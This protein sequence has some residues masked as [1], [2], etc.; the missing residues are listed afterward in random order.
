MTRPAVP[1]SGPQVASAPVTYLVDLS[2]RDQHLVTVTM[3]IP[4]D[5]A[6]TGGRLTVPTWTPG[7]Y[8]IRDY[9]HHLQR[10][11]ARDAAGRPV[12]LEP[13]GVS[14]WVLPPVDGEVVVDLEW[15]AFDASVRT[16]HVDDHYA[17]LVG[18][19]TFPCLEPARHRPHHVHL[20]GIAHDH[21]VAALLPGEHD[22]P[23]VAQ[24]H[25]HLVDSAFAIGAL[26]ASAV[27]VHGVEHRLVWAGHGDGVDVRG[28]TDDLGR[29]AHAAAAL[30]AGDLPAER[31]T[32]LAIDG[33]GGGLEHRDGCVVA[34]PP[35]ATTDVDRRRRLQSLLAHEHFHLWNVRRMMP[36]E[37]VHPPLDR[38]VL[39]TALWVAEG[40]TSYYDRLLPTRAGLWRAS[41]LL[42]SLD[43]LRDTVADLP[44]ARIQTLHDASRTA[45]TKF[46]RRDENT[47]NAGTDYYAHGALAAF[48]LDLRLRRI[49][50]DGDGLDAVLR[51]LWRRHGIDDAGRPL[52]YTEQ[53]VLDALARAGGEDV[54]R[55]AEHLT[56]VPGIPDPSQDLPVLALTEHLDTE[57]DAPR[58]GVLV[59]PEG[60]RIRLRSVLRDGAAWR[61]GVSGGDE[62]LAIE[63][64]T[65][66]P[67]ELSTVLRRH[68]PE[69]E[70]RLTLRR[71][72]RIVERVVRLEGALARPRLRLDESADAAALAR[73]TRWSGSPPPA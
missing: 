27:D 49:D 16:N 34:F 53:D 46:Y 56:T 17:L 2:G 29:I 5:L 37:L 40:W 42:S 65:L 11:A 41:D 21:D 50:P 26:R 47:P 71:G 32:V 36:H 44:G 66:A 72:P 73:F 69:A 63:G 58:M 9:V 4:T 10:V 51:D 67:E 52:G 31:Y 45:W 33:E 60:G 8:V 35:H 19:A 15:Y 22:G 30:F 12:R 55:L 3:R 59:Q 68:G 20:T 57:D 18:A 13:D 23:Y 25:D 38:P 48:V 61:A 43:R 62:L 54:A 39:T 6:A 1:S 64:E 14:S 70:V 28:M 7:S 24:D